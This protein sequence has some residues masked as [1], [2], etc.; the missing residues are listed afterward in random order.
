M[1][2]GRGVLVRV[3]KSAPED[4]DRCT[5]EVNRLDESFT[6]SVNFRIRYRLLFWGSST[7]R[8]LLTSNYE[9][10]SAPKVYCIDLKKR[11]CKLLCVFPTRESEQYAAL[12]SM[13]CS[14]SGRTIAAFIDEENVSS[15]C[16]ASVDIETKFVF[17]FRVFA[18]EDIGP[19]SFRM[20]P[21]FV[22]LLASD[23]VVVHDEGDIFKL[24][25]E[26]GREME[27]ERVSAVPYLGNVF[28]QERPEEMNVYSVCHVSGS[29]SLLALVSNS[30]FVKHDVPSMWEVVHVVLEDLNPD[31]DGQVHWTCQ[32]VIPSTFN[33]PGHCVDEVSQAVDVG[34]TVS[35]LGIIIDDA[36]YIHHFPALLSMK[37]GRLRQAWMTACIRSLEKTF[38]TSH[39]L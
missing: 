10:Y 24:G 36:K 19:P 5:L 7:N 16:V 4:Y 9:H 8:Y 27:F 21:C 13:T 35:Y 29:S 30:D 2:E 3:K 33:Q 25:R 14:G 34:V 15:V 17:N 32:V 26:N 1:L 31:I 12:H 11:K 39:K 22:G 37:L 18:C 6:I 20:L 38:C 23:L 28:A